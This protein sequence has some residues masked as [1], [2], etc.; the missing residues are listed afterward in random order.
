MK[1]LML[2]LSFV[3][4][5]SFAEQ[6]KIV[7]PYAPGGNTDV[8]ARLY[9]KH[10]NKNG[11]DAIII[12][13]PGAEGRVGQNEF[14]MQ[15]KPDGNTLLFTGVGSIIYNVLENDEDYN[16]MTK[17]VPVIQTSISGAILLTKKDSPYKTHEDLLNAA[18]TKQINIGTSST[19]YRIFS[20]DFYSGNKNIV[21]V[22]Y[23]GDAQTVNGLMSNSVDAVYVTFLFGKRV[24]EGE[25]NGLGV[26]TEN[27]YFG[28]KS[29]K[30]MGYNK[31][32]VMW[33]GFFAPPGTPKEKVD[34]WF[35]IIKGVKTDK[36]LIDAIINQTNAG[37]AP[38]R[39]PEEFRTQIQQEYRN[40]KK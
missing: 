12:N 1:K 35:N 4:S 24:V 20:S 16:L 21:L 30:E 39:S 26:S 25:F 11:I 14:I 37:M 2:M 27:S 23:N 29:F 40:L 9:A 34:H 7:V 5:F 6:L 18:K 38:N 10:L 19:A 33:N 8:T 22:P 31:K 3:C 36:E 17:L 32:L 15:A 13:K 28:V